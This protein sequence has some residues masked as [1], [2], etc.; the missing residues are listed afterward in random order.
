MV[1]FL[2]VVANEVVAILLGPG[3][4][5]AAKVFR[6]L[7]PAALLGTVNVAPGW[8][9]VS[10][11]RAGVQLL[12]A[13][14]SAPLMVVSF[15][16]GVHWGIVG[17]AAAFSVGWSLLFVLFVAMACHRSPVPFGNLVKTLLPSMFAACTAAAAC[18]MLLYESLSESILLS[19]TIN[20]ALFSVVYL[21]ISCAM[22]SGRF[23][24]ETLWCDGLSL[25]FRRAKGTPL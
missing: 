18:L 16:V 5:D 24:I 11:G 8:L 7:A 21:A 2:F 6:W 23:R 25:F 1:A 19:L 12:W 13:A 14:I 15:I 22:P 10:L 17:V 9:C 4:E 20:G 3:W